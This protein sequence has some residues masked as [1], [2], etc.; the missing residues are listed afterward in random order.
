M[1][2][3]LW[4]PH[5]GIVTYYLYANNHT[6]SMEPEPSH[7]NAPRPWRGTTWCKRGTSCSKKCFLQ[8]RFFHNWNSVSRFV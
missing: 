7:L 2:P 1:P 4:H 5:N 6:I 3:P 8:S